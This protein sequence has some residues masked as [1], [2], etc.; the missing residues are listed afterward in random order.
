MPEYKNA[1]SEDT[2][3]RQGTY[4]QVEKS[5][6]LSPEEQHRRAKAL[7]DPNATVQHN[8]YVKNADEVRVAIEEHNRVVEM[9][10]DVSVVQNEFKGLKDAVSRADIAPA[11]G[12]TTIKAHVQGVRLGEHADKTRLVL[13]LDAPGDF[14]F[15]LDNAQNLLVISLPGTAWSTASERVF[16]N[17]KV[18]RAYAAKP[19]QT[20]GS[21]VAVK[22]R[23]PSKVLGS[24]KLGK[25]A[26][27][28]HRIFLDVAPL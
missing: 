6:A 20:G 26:A 3:E 5:D 18:L 11:A 23:G 8:R 15:D 19:S 1:R 16:N 27:G 24:A 2:L 13:D 14:E 7:V 25:N 10:R 9:E 17:S 21:V 4:E 22:L 28:M 12:S